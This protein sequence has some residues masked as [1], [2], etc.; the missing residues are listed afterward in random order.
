MTAETSLRRRRPGLRP[1]RRDG[2]RGAGQPGNAADSNDCVLLQ[3]ARFWRS[4]SAGVAAIN[5]NL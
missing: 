3:G 5:L 4:G 1:P 2:R